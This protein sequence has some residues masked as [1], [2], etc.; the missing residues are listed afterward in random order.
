MKEGYF[1]VSL[2]L[3]DL[4]RKS[5]FS[6]IQFCPQCGSF[7]IVK[8][9]FYKS[10]QRYHCKTC[11]KYFNDLTNTIFSHCR[12]LDKLIPYINSM[13]YSLP[14]KKAGALV[15]VSYV[16]LFYWRHKVIEAF[17]KDETQLFG[18]LQCVDTA[19]NYSEKGNKKLFHR[20][21]HVR[22]NGYSIASLGARDVPL[23]SI[24]DS[25]LTI[26]F[27]HM[28]SNRL[29]A[30]DLSDILMPFTTNVT[31]WHTSLH[32][33]Y[34]HF[35]M[36]HHFKHDYVV[37][38]TDQKEVNVKKAHD[39]LIALKSWLAI[40]K[41]VATKY[42]NNYLSWFKVLLDIYTKNNEFTYTSI[43]K[44]ILLFCKKFQPQSCIIK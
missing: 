17:K 24:V 26:K 35:C 37:G 25:D 15:G 33:T 39:N 8:F 1:M 21:A 31:H 34:K 32:S 2:N 44:L 6:P 41:G 40:F 28:P 43:L 20:E 36:F 22:G 9:G 14:L 13:L 42:L 3:I 19:I 16:N 18:I 11:G 27:L 30:N 5:R 7:E 4:I 23:L 29:T 10:T 12:V 38:F